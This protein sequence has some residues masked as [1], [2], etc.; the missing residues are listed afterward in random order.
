MSPLIEARPNRPK[1]AETTDL[2]VDNP[3]WIRIGNTANQPMQANMNGVWDHDYG[4]PLHGLV[5]FCNAKPTS[6]GRN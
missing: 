1:F 3:T 4:D 5:E 6:D 2:N